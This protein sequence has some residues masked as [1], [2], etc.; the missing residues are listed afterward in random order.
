MS[1]TEKTISSILGKMGE[2]L[3]KNQ[4]MILDKVLVSEFIDKEIIEQNNALVVYDGMSEKLISQFLTVKSIDGCSDKTINTY[5]FH[6]H[7]L[8]DTI[9]TK[10]VLNLTT[11]DIRG[12]LA[13]YKER[14]KVSNVT[15]NNMRHS[16]SSFFKYLHESGYIKE[17]PM[18]Q[19]S[20]IKTKQII[21]KPFSDEELEKLRICCAS[22]ERNLAIIEFLYSTGV[23]VS[24]MCALN[25]DQIDFN[26]KE[27]IVFG[28]GAKERIVYINSRAYIH[29]QKYLHMRTDSNPA[30]FVG[31]RK[32]Y[33]RISKEGVE[34]M[35]RTVG[36]K[37]G[38]QNTHPHRF[39]R[40][41]ATNALNRGMPLQE[42]QKILGHAKT[43]TTMSYCT[44]S[45]ENVKLSHKKYIA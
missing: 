23:R 31:L 41:M 11:N 2:H 21:K 1:A 34:T 13:I 20:S 8:I 4:L 28:K 7:K 32:P 25:R 37:A 15:L 40:T 16:M 45:Q 14:R 3:D 38:V 30:L 5:S 43:D 9:T 35:L 10:S 18:R 29:L 42:V 27:C 33:G 17:N 22:N 44:V 36:R 26:Q 19:I 24:E 6:L 39:R 12:F